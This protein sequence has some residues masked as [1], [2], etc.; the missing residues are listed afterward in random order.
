[1]LDPG[2]LLLAPG[3]QH[4]RLSDDRRLRLT[5]EAPEG[6]LRPRADFTIQ[7][8]ARSFG[9]R[10][11]LV[12]PTGMGKD[13]LD[14]AHAVKRMGGRVLAEA[15]STCTVYGMPRAVAEARLA[16]RVGPAAR[17]PPRRDRGGARMSLQQGAARRPLVPKF[18]PVDD[19]VTFCEAVRRICG[20]DLLQYK[21]GQMERRIRAWTARGGTQDLAAYARTGE[22]ISASAAELHRTA[23]S[24]RTLVARFTLAGEQG[25]MDPRGA[26]GL[27]GWM[28]THISDSTD[29]T[30]ARA[31]DEAAFGRL[32]APH[33]AGLHAHCYRMLG[34]AARRR[35]RAAGRAAARLA[36]PAALR[37]PQLAALLALQR[38]PRTSACG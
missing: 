17:P 1:M 34:S 35:G 19:Y 3:G 7:D 4:L 15:E 10:L 18:A 28:I 32:V 16:D 36:R 21:R 5:D 26:A 24:L 27:Y 30:A 12:V 13:G 20:V 6:G 31:G 11:V 23:E 38:S 33:R 25:A 8:A 22:Q 37:G 9:R 29:L 2:T 14:G